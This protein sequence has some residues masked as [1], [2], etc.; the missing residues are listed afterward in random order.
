[1]FRRSVVIVGSFVLLVAGSYAGSTSAAVQSWTNSS[2]NG[3]WDLVSPNWDTSYGTAWS[4]GNSAEFGGLATPGS[5]TVSGAR[6]VGNI[7]F[8]TSGYT[9]TG[10]SLNLTGGTIAANQNAE[11]D[12][13]LTGSAGLNQTGAGLL[14]LTNGANNYTGGTVVSAGTL[15]LGSGSNDGTTNAHIGITGNYSIASGATLVIAGTTAANGSFPALGSAFSGAGTLLVSGNNSLLLGSGVEASKEYFAL[16]SAFSG[17]VAVQNAIAI[18]NGPTALGGATAVQV[19]QTGQL[20]LNSAGT[21]GTAITVSGSGGNQSWDTLGSGAIF[22]NSNNVTLSGPITLTAPSVIIG[23]TGAG[24][25]TTITG[26][27]SGNYAGWFGSPATAYYWHIVLAP[28]GAAISVPSV[29]TKAGVDVV[30]GN[31]NAFGTSQWNLAG[32]SNSFLTANGFNVSLAA[33]TGNGIVRNNASTSGT[34]NIG[35]D[36][37]SQTFNGTFQDG[38]GG[39]SLAIVK[40][41]SGSFMITQVSSGFSGGVT[42]NQGTLVLSANGGGTPVV[43]SNLITINTGG[44]LICTNSGG[45]GNPLGGV[46]VTPVYVNGGTFIPAQYDD[47]NS[48]TMNAGTVAVGAGALDFRNTAAGSAPTIATSANAVTAVIA[49][50]MTI[51]STNGLTATVAAGGGV[52]ADLLISGAIGGGGGLVKTGTGIALFTGGQSYSGGTTVSAGTL[53]VG[54]TAGNFLANGA[55]SINSGAVL[56]LAGNNNMPATLS[57]YS[58][59]GL[60][61]VVGINTPS[62]TNASSQFSTS[63]SSAFSGTIAA[64]NATYNIS[65]PSSYGGATLLQTVQNGQLLLQT[66]GTYS[67]PMSVSGLGAWNTWG[68]GNGNPTGAIL[69]WANNTTVAGPITLTGDAIVYDEVNG[70][71]ATTYTGPISG[72]YTATFGGVSGGG[73]DTLTLAPTGAGISCPNAIMAGAY[74]VLKAGNNNAFG[75]SDWSTI[76]GTIATNGYNPSMGG[77]SSVSG[78]GVVQNG[79][80]TAST[81]TVGDATNQT[82]TGL[83]QN[84]SIGSL[85]LVKTGTGSWTM[86]GGD[87]FTGGMAISQGTLVAGYTG[88]AQNWGV[89]NAAGGNITVASGAVLRATAANAVFGYWGSSGGNGGTWT[90]TISNSGVMD[91]AASGNMNLGPLTLAG[92]ELRASGAGDTYGTWNLNYDVNVTANSLISANNVDLGG[93]QTTGQRTFTV[94]PGVTLNVTGF[95]RNGGNNGATAYGLNLAGNGTMI[96]AG[97]DTYTGPTNVNGGTLQLGNVGAINNSSALT[98]NGAL[99]FSPGLASYSVP[100]LAGSG[101][102]TLADTNGLGINLAIGSNG[103]ST[104]FSGGLSGSS[105]SLTKVGSGT[106][107]LSGTNTYGGTTAVNAGSLVAATTAALPGYASAGTVSVASGATLGVRVGGAGEWGQGDISTLL[108]AATFP[109]GS[110]LGLD[111]TDAGGSFTYATPIPGALGFNKLGSGVLVLPGASTY[112]GPTLVTA[113]TLQ[114]GNGTSG[115]GLTSTSISVA[116]GAAIGFNHGDALTYSGSIGGM[117]SLVKNGSGTL[118]L[119]GGPNVNYSGGTT[120]SAG[121]LQLG[122]GSNDGTSNANIGITGNYNI[123]GGATLVVAGTTANNGSFPVLGSAFSGAG[124]L[125]LN[126][127]SLSSGTIQNKSNESFALTSAFSGTVALQNATAKVSSPS[128]FGGATAID[129]LPAGQ[130]SLNAN[131]TYGVSIAVSGSGTSRSWD[132]TGSG[133]IIIDASNITLSGSITLTAPSV[134]LGC[135]DVA[136]T[137]TITGP[138]SGLYAAQ[139]GSPA[140]Y[141]YYHIV[142]APTGAAISVPSVTTVAGIDVVAG[143]ANAFGTSKWNI[144]GGGD[145]FLTTNGYNVS[146]AALSGNGVVRNNSSTA[147]TITIGSDNSNQTF[148]GL[149]IDGGTASASLALDKTGTGTLRLSGGNTYS[150]GTTVNAGVLRYGVAAALS[151]TGTVN[152][153]GASAVLDLG[154]FS[155]TVGAFTLTSGTLQ[156]GTLTAASCEVQSGL[157]AAVL[158]GGSGVGLTKDTAGLVVLT[159]ANTYGG[160]TTISAGTLEL[161]GG[162]TTGSLNT[163]SAI[164]DNGVLAF[165]RSN[166]V[167]QSSDFSSAGITGSGS[168]VQAGTGI[169]VLSLS[170]G[171]TGGTVIQNG[172]LQLGSA[173]AL[174]TGSLAVNGG[175]LDLNGQSVTVSSFSGAAGTITDNRSFGSDASFIVN[176]SASI[177]FGGSFQA[178]SYGHLVNLYQE[179]SGTL[180]LNGASNNLASAN[181]QNTVTLQIG[182]NV[183]ATSFNLSG[184][185]LIA[186]SGTISLGTGGLDYASSAAC[187]FAGTIAG[188][189]GIK[190]DQG[191]LTLSGANNIFAGGATITG[192]TLALGVN[193][194]LPSG[195]IAFGGANNG[196]FDLAGFNQTVTGLMVNGGTP[197]AQII[198][199]SSANPS[200]LTFNGA[201]GS[202]FAGTIR[203]HLGSGSGSVALTVSNGY[204]TLNGVNT[205]S[206]TTTVSGGV[207]IAGASNALSPNSPV[208]LSSGI[209]DASGYGEKILSLTM[210]SGGALVLGNGNVLTS[211]GS[212][213]LTGTLD[214][215]GDTGSAVLMTYSSESG[216]FSSHSALPIGYGLVYGKSELTISSTGTPT[217]STAT[218]GS[219]KDNT[220]WTSYSVPNAAGQSAVVNAP[221]ATP[222]TISLD[223]PQTLGTLTLG[224]STSNTV[225]YT[226]TPG[227]SG[228][229]TLANTGSSPALITVTGGSQAIAANVAL[230]GSLTIAPSA[231]TTLTIAGNMSESI[232]GSGSLLLN[233]AGTLILSGSNGFTGGTVVTNGTLILTNNEALAGGSSLT[234]G[235]ASA[236]AGGPGDANPGAISSGLSAPLAASP[237]IT[238]VPEPGTLLLLAVGGLLTIAY[239][240]CRK[241]HAS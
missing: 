197:S 228:S 214:L 89:F 39:G 8:D 109:T 124:T 84:G 116:S 146:V 70:G 157:V 13:L 83:I 111:T 147:S 32:G 225:G 170:N 174:G 99:T 217:W 20:F 126:G 114:I 42:V 33:L 195:T 19:S 117:G 122:S 72:P 162:G 61:N 231:E 184:G 2:A 29:S 151:S 133:A 64:Q 205:Y 129:V 188:A 176:Q 105:G 240:R 143:N 59:G 36:N 112:G 17:T 233:D 6:G 135:T 3:I 22:I 86:T 154:G 196:T 76:R 194:A 21:Y 41:G 58:G 215:S 235:D 44:T 57:G 97:A 216:S 140:T 159:A 153:N 115:E 95:F 47:I 175:T 81:L 123:A 50:P 101:S 160:A 227:T 134:V 223:S 107:T 136:A 66:S 53:Q 52:G 238:P 234:I 55:Y 220:M 63:F 100:S 10:G 203:D 187:N 218:S 152:V 5:I 213:E 191:S 239:R 48:L 179:G 11:I 104:L 148:S 131:G 54:T 206:G 212:A 138:I 161:G 193:N 142:L 4:D 209:L 130:L 119:T 94:N 26:P 155:P 35:F 125:L 201:G 75:T 25:T 219:W 62:G 137:T 1:M 102:V 34:V 96:L 92:G 49:A 108:G 211:T 199:N 178:G 74:L 200:L 141:Y 230:A 80:A 177:A 91:D 31:A 236:F 90:A 173:A 87:T 79:A 190:V 210:G 150:G 208:F 198:G 77:L 121:T 98:V 60:L 73:G 88:N 23:D 12:S 37:S 43:G 65:S 14:L 202:T 180:A 224:N 78:N 93:N 158:A 28:T 30:A 56:Q 181:V 185:G 110:I 139:F 144:N 71:N 168:V 106:L 145:S 207:L 113:G 204:L 9:I 85:A 7:T 221:T 67:V 171:Y 241:A 149:I 229:L 69:I 128:N 103:T 226:L 169:L 51:T 172:T 40:T 156:N 46:P 189:G 27:I 118:M 132:S 186:G 182:G 15:Q 232:S 38:S 45:G 183:T 165:N 18:A 127:N 192:G 164:A 120:I 16:T 163:S 68:G 167:S 82:Y 237:S 222:V 166:T 24:G